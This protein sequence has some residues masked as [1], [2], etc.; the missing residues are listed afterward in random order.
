[1]SWSYII[2]QVIFIKAARPIKIP[3]QTGF[4][5]RFG[6]ARAC[7]KCTNIFA[8]TFVHWKPLWKLLFIGMNP[9]VQK[10]PRRTVFSSAFV[11][12]ACSVLLDW[13][14]TTL[15]EG[16]SSHWVCRFKS[17]VYLHPFSCLPVAYLSIKQPHASALSSNRS[18][19][20]FTGSLKHCRLRSLTSAFRLSHPP[21]FSDAVLPNHLPL[22]STCSIIFQKSNAP[23]N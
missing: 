8:C 19:Q 6:T 10:H 16:I 18:Q 4:C 12:N 14:A 3:R 9:L 11:H 22:F 7:W 21:H 2:P 1:M 5:S 17:V 20:T 23:A 15:K 13:T